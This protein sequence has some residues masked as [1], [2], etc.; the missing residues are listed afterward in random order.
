MPTLLYPY[1]LPCESYM[2]GTFVVPVARLERMS[3]RDPAGFVV[4]LAIP[5]SYRAGPPCRGNLPGNLPAATRPRLPA[6]AG[7]SSAY[8]LDDAMSL[9]LHAAGRRR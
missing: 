7:S 5:V 2:N 4:R 6:E 8:P 3:R 1:L 9:M